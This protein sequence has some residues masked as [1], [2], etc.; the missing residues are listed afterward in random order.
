[1]IHAAEGCMCVAGG[2]WMWQ[3]QMSWLA[4]S[5]VCRHLVYATCV[6]DAVH[7]FY[8]HSHRPFYQDI[9]SPPNPF[10]WNTR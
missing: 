4:V 10:V 3:W 9:N 2:R 5:H 6:R 7:L 8:T 1:M